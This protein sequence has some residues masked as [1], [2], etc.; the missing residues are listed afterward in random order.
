MSQA[1][2]E[3]SSA[4]GVSWDLS[5]LYGGVDDPRVDGDLEAAGR[6]ARSFEET[7]RGTI[8]VDGGPA[9]DWLRGAIA[10]Y[11]SLSEQMDKP[12][13]YAGLLHAAKTDDP[14]R[15]ALLA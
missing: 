13:V 7:Y 6:R 14:R 1:D 4:D 9:S 2:R 10:E 3:G 15:G 8:Q 5:D 11:E 12:C